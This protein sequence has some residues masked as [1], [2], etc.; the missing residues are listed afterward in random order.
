MTPKK[1]LTCRRRSRPCCTAE[2]KIIPW[3]LATTAKPR[4]RQPF[5]LTEEILLIF[6]RLQ[7]VK[8]VSN[9]VQCSWLKTLA[10]VDELFLRW[11]SSVAGKPVL[12]ADQYCFRNS[13]D[14]GKPTIED[15]HARAGGEHAFQLTTELG[16][17]I[18]VNLV[19][20]SEFS[21]SL[22]QS[23]PSRSWARERSSSLYTHFAL[24]GFHGGLQLRIGLGGDGRAARTLSAHR[25]G[26]NGLASRAPRSVG[27]PG[28]P[29]CWC[30]CLRIRPA[31]PSSAYQEC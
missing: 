7:F 17:V 10:A 24:A 25:A 20:E 2:V 12:K 9:K 26:T 27:L 3:V 19:A 8:L 28:K 11:A 18:E 22:P 1:C 6:N 4:F 14:Q 21:A 16:R 5:T 23:K 29:L 15:L 13:G 30:L 31:H